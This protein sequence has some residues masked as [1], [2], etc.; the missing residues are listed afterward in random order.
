LWNGVFSH[1]PVQPGAGLNL[2]VVE[3]RAGE[4]KSALATLDRPL[5]F[6]PDNA[7]ARSM[8]VELRRGKADLREEMKTTKARGAEKLHRARIA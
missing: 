5:I 7:K 8:A 6:A 1:D 4:G 2:A 3:C